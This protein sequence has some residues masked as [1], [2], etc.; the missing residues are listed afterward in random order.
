MNRRMALLLYDDFFLYGSTYFLVKK[1]N[2]KLH[3]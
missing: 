2:K 1:L 3:K